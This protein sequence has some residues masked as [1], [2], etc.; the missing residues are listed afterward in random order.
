M[1]GWYKPQSQF[2]KKVIVPL[3]L[4][5][6]RVAE[7]LNVL[8]SGNKVIYENAQFP[9]VKMLEEKHEV[10]LSELSGILKT[11]QKIPLFSDLSEEQKRITPGDDWRV[12]LMIAYGK[13]LPNAV[14]TCP[15]TISLL[16][17]IPGIESAMFSILEPGAKI[18]PHRGPYNGV[19][20]YHLGLI[21][22]Q[23]FNDCGIRIH[24]TIYHW[25]KGQSIIFDDSFEHEVWNNT[26]ENRVVL[27]IDF[28]R[29]LPFPVNIINKL[30]LN[31]LARSPFIQTIIERAM[32][33]AAEN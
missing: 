11:Q 13:T 31:L 5:P 21:V 4:F 24:Q 12:Y 25:Q 29:P 3:L 15:Q 6:V 1:A 17:K 7:A 33:A 28:D 30:F 18:L 20:R 16:H 26:A 22:P 32:D 10:I 19:L 2:Y 8:V 14:A 27:F 23:N 9:W